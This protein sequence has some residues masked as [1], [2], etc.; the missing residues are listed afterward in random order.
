MRDGLF[1]KSLQHRG[2]GK[3]G[4]GIR[5]CR[6]SISVRK[7]RR[8]DGVQPGLGFRLSGRLMSPIHIII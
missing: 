7:G 2:N 4:K 1:S 3:L 8:D 6:W 5:H